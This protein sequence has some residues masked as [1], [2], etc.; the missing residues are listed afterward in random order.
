MQHKTYRNR[1]QA[2]FF[3]PVLGTILTLLGAGVIVA[4]H[5]SETEA[6]NSEQV[7]VVE[8]QDSGQKQSYT[9]NDD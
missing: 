4:T 7:S 9:F 1:K 8:Q 5:P 6:L 3:D 2:G